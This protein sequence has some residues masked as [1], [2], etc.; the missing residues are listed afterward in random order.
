[1]NAQL[2]NPF[3]IDIPD[4]VSTTLS[5]AECTALLFNHGLSTLAGQY[6]AV[7]RSDGLVTIWDIETRSVLRVLAGH[8]RPVAGLAWSTYNRYLATCAS[9]AS[10]IVWDLAAKSYAG[11]VIRS[12]PPNRV[13][14]EEEE[15]KGK[16]KGESEARLPSCSERKATLRFD[17]AVS[18]VQ[19]APGDS[20]RLV[21]V[22][23]SN[24]AFLV[25]MGEKVRVR[26]R[27]PHPTTASNSSDY[28]APVEVEDVAVPSRTPLLGPTSASDDDDTAAGVG[29]ITA[30]RFTPDT[31]FIVAGTTKGLLLIFDA[32][33]GTLLSTSK[34]LST[35]SSVRSLSFD[36]AGRYCVVNCNDRALR[37]LSLTS[38]YSQL[39]L[40]LLHKV[41]DMVQRTPWTSASF[42]PSA[43]Y[44][45]AGAAHKAAHNVYVWDRVSGVLLKM[46]EG[47]KDFVV[48]VDWHP[49]R[50]VVASASNTGAVYIWFSPADEIW[51][52]YADGFE[53]LDENVEYQ[54]AEDEFDFDEHESTSRR[55]Q[56]EQ[57]AAHV[58]VTDG[59][60][61]HGGA[62]KRCEVDKEEVYAMLGI[63]REKGGKWER[64]LEKVLDRTHR[65]ARDEGR[66]AAPGKEEEEVRELEFTLLDDDDSDAFVIPPRLEIDYSDFHDDHL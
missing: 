13:G 36:A 23:A 30:A 18:S 66:K 43:D 4:S 62:R 21:V 17:C 28:G 54:E 32:S 51:S 47:P 53:E 59:E 34:V 15:G 35:S 1:M 60:Q 8:V 64:A 41:Q 5:S 7:G 39:D 31:R 26:R 20:R 40:V 14:S 2:L 19:F 33:T 58:R 25:D 44:V 46:L 56:H 24:E 11:P 49:H 38:P 29:S 16:E 9:D 42:T 57:E 65:L 55:R 3:S 12:G 63:D 50:P 61:Q 10:V 37:I 22:L 6:L 27:R 45:Y 52:A 48:G